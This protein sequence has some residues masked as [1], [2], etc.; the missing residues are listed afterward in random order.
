MANTDP[1]LTYQITSGSLVSGDSL[2][3]ALTRVSG[4]NVGSYAIQQGS[5]AASANYALTFIGANLSIG[6]RSLTTT[7]DAKSKV[8]GDTDPA[9]T[10]QITSGSLVSGDSLTGALTRVSGENV[11]TVRHTARLPGRQRQLCPDLHRGQPQHRHAQSDD[12]RRRQEQGLWGHRPALTYQITSGSLVSGDSLTGA[13]TRVPGETVGTYAIQQG[14]LAASA[15]YALT[16]AGANLTISPRAITVTADD[17]SKLYGANL[18][19][20]GTAFMLS[21]G[22]F[23]GDTLTNVTL[24]SAGTPPAAP[25]GSYPIVPS[26]AKGIGL[27]NY[28]LAY[29]PG[30]LTVTQGLTMATVGTVAYYPTNYPP[31]WSGG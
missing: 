5:L 23:N 18:V 22:L 9:L 15:N 2:T 25:V 16:Y 27:A 31:A 1:A 14:S 4:E 3:G 21:G 11:G 6:T 20:D 28:N 8:Y 17:C 24:T 30:T 29:L 13:L 19:L 26:G 10:Y 7:A 12:H